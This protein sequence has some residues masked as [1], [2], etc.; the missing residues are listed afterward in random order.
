MSNW[1]KWSK[2]LQNL[3][4]LRSK[5]IAFRKFDKAKDLDKIENITRIKNRL[6]TFCQV[7][8]MA[9]VGGLTVGIT[10][11]DSMLDRCM[12]IFGLKTPSDR[13]MTSEGESM[14]TTWF[15]SPEEGLK[16]QCDYPRIPASYE[17][18]I[19]IGPLTEQKFDPEVIIIYGNPAQV[20]MLMCGLQ[21]EKYERFDFSFIGEGACSN[22]LAQCYVNSKPAVAIPCYGERA[23]GQVADDELVIALPPGEIERAIS[24]IKKLAKLG[25]RY[26]IN[27]IGSEADVLPFLSKLYPKVL[28]N[29]RA[30]AIKD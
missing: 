28:D 21:K 18:A 13:S 10:R 4:H 3:L 16:Q 11:H 24:G 27:Y 29:M 8:F 22:S 17:G 15:A 23:F 2:E 14:A 19:V 6:F 20:M 12:R 30:D 1:A 25:L 5:I 7:P 9:R 26:P